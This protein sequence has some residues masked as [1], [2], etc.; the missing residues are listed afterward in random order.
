VSVAPASEAGPD[1]SAPSLVPV[2]PAASAP[3]VDAFV[4]A[5]QTDIDEDSSKHR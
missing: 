4:K 5:V 3:P 2:I 1:D